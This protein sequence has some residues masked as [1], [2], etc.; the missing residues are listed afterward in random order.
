MTAL[1]T[2]VDGRPVPPDVALSFYEGEPIS[3]LAFV[4]RIVDYMSA[5][6]GFLGTPWIIWPLMLLVAAGVPAAALW[7]LYRALTVRP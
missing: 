7:V 6:R 2:T 4:P 5:F 1:R 3:A